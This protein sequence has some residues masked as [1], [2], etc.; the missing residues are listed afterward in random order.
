MPFEDETGSMTANLVIFEN[1]TNLIRTLP[2][3]T[4]D[5]TNPNDV[6]VTPHEITHAPDALR[7]FVA[8][9]PTPAVKVQPQ[10]DEESLDRQLENF[11]NF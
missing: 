6:A 9:R 1:C 7:Y 11:I 4:Y 3:L 10:E 8:G 2:A 5:K